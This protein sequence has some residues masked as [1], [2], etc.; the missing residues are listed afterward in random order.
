[1]WTPNRMAMLTSPNSRGLCVDRS[2]HQTPAT[3]TRQRDFV[4]ASQGLSER[5]RV[6]ARN[7]PGQWGPSDHCQVDIE[8]D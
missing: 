8:V 6:S 1:M 7:A 3:A 4:F 2:S 5:L